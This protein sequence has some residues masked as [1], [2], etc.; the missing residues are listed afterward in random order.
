MVPLNKKEQAMP[1]VTEIL[2][3]QRKLDKL[4]TM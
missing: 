2:V 4:F 3:K 1:L